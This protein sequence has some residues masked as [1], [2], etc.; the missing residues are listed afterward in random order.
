MLKPGARQNRIER[1]S[2]RSGPRFLIIL[3]VCSALAAVAAYFM[4]GRQTAPGSRAQTADIDLQALKGRW[5][6]A[7][8]GYVLEIRNIDPDGRMDAAYFNPR[9]INV[10]RAEAS[11]QGDGMNVFLELRDTGYPGCT[12]T[13][14]YDPREDSLKGV[15]YQAAVQQSFE[16]IFIRMK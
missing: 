10:S 7:D 6:R 14:A 11:R 3:I 15:Y 8:G 9:P 4:L 2:P 1:R 12:Y 16:V 13:M 5:F